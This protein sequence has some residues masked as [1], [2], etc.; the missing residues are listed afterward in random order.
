V[1]WK[2]SRKLSSNFDARSGSWS[3]TSKLITNTIMG[4][5]VWMLMAT[6][7]RMET[8]GRKTNVRNAAA[9]YSSVH[10][11]MSQFL[12]FEWCG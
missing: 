3:I 2:S 4:E 10:F 9:R 1:H 11:L 7:G 8:H 5:S 6:G 12:F